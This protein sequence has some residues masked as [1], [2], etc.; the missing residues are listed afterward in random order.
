[1]NIKTKL[2]SVR[3]NIKHCQGIT[4]KIEHGCYCVRV[5][6]REYKG[7]NSVLCREETLLGAL[8]SAISRASKLNII[9]SMGK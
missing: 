6:G 1:M 4:C 5:I 3:K 9:E 2:E 7:V 8:K